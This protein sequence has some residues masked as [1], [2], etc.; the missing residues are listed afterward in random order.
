MVKVNERGLL[1]A[2]QPHIKRAFSAMTDMGV[3]E[4]D[5]KRAEFRQRE[6]HWHLSLE[7]AAPAVGIALGAA[8]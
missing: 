6:P 2:P 3:V 7:H 1:A 8:R 5:D 4:A